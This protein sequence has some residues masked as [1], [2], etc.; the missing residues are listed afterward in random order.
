M[1]L[2]W[3]AIGLL[4]AAALAATATAD[5]VDTWT[6]PGLGGWTGGGTGVALTNAGGCLSVE[7]S[8]QA[9]PSP[10]SC[11][12][13]RCVDSYSTLSNL[14][15]RLCAVNGSPSAVRLYFHSAASGNQWYVNLSVPAAG[16][17][18]NGW[19]NRQWPGL[20]AE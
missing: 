11:I 12:A 7:F 10:L 2:R 16:G 5:T 8:Q 9:A 15:F 3:I 14:S 13:S 17:D 4:L 18:G 6:A 20:P 19:G 1:R